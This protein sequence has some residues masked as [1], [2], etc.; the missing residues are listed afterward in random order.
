[1]YLSKIV[2]NTRNRG[3]MA[4]I[5]NMY[6]M[7]QTLISMLPGYDNSPDSKYLY[8]LEQ[9][10]RRNTAIIQMQSEIEP[11]FDKHFDT[12]YLQ[13]AQSK[14][15]SPKFNNG[16]QYRFR[17]YANAVRKRTY[18]P[19]KDT[20]PNPNKKSS[21][22]V[23]VPMYK[24]DEMEKWLSDRAISNGF[25]LL[26]Q[27]NMAKSYRKFS[28]KGESAHSSNLFGVQYDGILRITDAEQFAEALRSGIG[29]G[30]AFGFGLLS[31]AKI[32]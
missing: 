11:C 13:I 14:E 2:L 24:E 15:Y 21:E 19:D 22:S 29:K 6:S 4:D 8:R 26:G 23:L 32:V 3:V 1:M 17:L 25:E 27:P 7:H 18:N 28:K 10:E 20:N 31:V 16:E 30:K 5:S 12:G 9:D